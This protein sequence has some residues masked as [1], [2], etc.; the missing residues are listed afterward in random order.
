MQSVRG[1]HTCMDEVRCC[2]RSSTRAQL[3]RACPVHL[4]T[5]PPKRYRCRRRTSPATWL[6]R[7][8]RSGVS[9]S[10]LRIVWRVT[11]LLR[12]ALQPCMAWRWSWGAP[13]APGVVLGPTPMHPPLAPSLTHTPCSLDHSPLTH[14]PTHAHVCADWICRTVASIWSGFKSRMLDRWAQASASAGGSAD[15]AGPSAAGGAGDAYPGT[16]LG[17]GAPQVC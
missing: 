10:G 14:T 12:A 2:E 13:G 4:L 1:A 16:L 9:G 17:A 3:P 6:H 11:L 7:A 5:Q 15:K 8:R